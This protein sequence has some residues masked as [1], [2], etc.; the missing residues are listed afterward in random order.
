MAKKITSSLSF[1][2]AL[3]NI[4]IP[5]INTTTTFQ[6][7]E[8]FSEFR[9]P[10]GTT[11]NEKDKPMYSEFEKS[12]LNSINYIRS[13]SESI[14][15]EE[16]DAACP[17]IKKNDTYKHYLMVH[18]D[19]VKRINKGTSHKIS[20]GFRGQHTEDYTFHRDVAYGFVD[21]IFYFVFNHQT[22]QVELKYNGSAF[23]RIYQSQYRDIVSNITGDRMPINIHNEDQKFEAFL[24]LVDEFEFIPFYVE[25]NDGVVISHKAYRDKFYIKHDEFTSPCLGINI[26]KHE[27]IMEKLTEYLAAGRKIQDNAYYL[28]CE[29]RQTKDLYLKRYTD[30]KPVS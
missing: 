4:S 5:N 3:A 28:V 14:T 24:S 26:K 20:H 25:T 13:T 18:A 21:V 9:L 27:T 30:W 6:N 29:N 15:K 8:N 1:A 2:E 10:F 7:Y 17:T 16:I 11:T 22:M 19:R 23:N 12:L